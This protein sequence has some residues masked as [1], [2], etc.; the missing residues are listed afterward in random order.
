MAWCRLSLGSRLL[1]RLFVSGNPWDSQAALAS[2]F[3]VVRVNR[4]GDPPMNMAFAATL[5][6]NYTT[7]QDSPSFWYRRQRELFA[8]QCVI[9]SGYLAAHGSASQKVREDLSRVY[10]PLGCTPLFWKLGC[11]P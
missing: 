10:A 3:A 6:P 5:S 1:E 8:C 9:A 4:Y 2:G 11:W 7:S